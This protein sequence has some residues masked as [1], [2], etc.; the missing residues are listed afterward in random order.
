MSNIKSLICINCE[1]ESRIIKYN[2]SYYN[3]AVSKQSNLNIDL[4]T[5]CKEERLII[6][7]NNNLNCIICNKVRQVIIRQACR[8]TYNCFN[9]L[10]HND[11]YPDLNAKEKEVKKIENDLKSPINDKKEVKQEFKSPV[12]KPVVKPSPKIEPAKPVVPVKPEKKFANENHFNKIGYVEP[13]TVMKLFEKKELTVGKVL[14]EG[15]FKSAFKADWNGTPVVKMVF[16]LDNVENAVALKNFKE[17]LLVI[18]KMTHPNIIQ[19]LGRCKDEPAFVIGYCSNGS[20][21]DLIFRADKR[22]LRDKLSMNKK[23]SIAIQIARAINFMHH[24]SPPMLHRDLKSS[25]ILLNDHLDALVTDF[26]LTLTMM[27]TVGISKH[28]GEG[29]VNYMSPETFIVNGPLISQATDV[30]SYGCVLIEI[31]AYAIPWRDFEELEIGKRVTSQ[32]NYLPPE[33]DK[34]C[35]ASIKTLIGKCLRRDP[36]KRISFDNIISELEKIV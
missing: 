36:S 17:E 1:S 23:L 28:R 10:L 2:L 35:N 30:W 5:R 21:F 7:N 18:S 27:K 22:A 20:L 15:S 25:N 13:A 8:Q 26:G 32:D 14:G 6:N 34:V 4:C 12:M 19:F 29:T 3:K 31:F 11:M 16:H 9:C 24:C 33:L